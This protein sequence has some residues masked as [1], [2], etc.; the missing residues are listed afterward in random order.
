MKTKIC[1][2]THLHDAKLAIESGAWAL[3]FNFYKHSPRFLQRE[4]AREI[5][6]ALPKEIL[7]I[8]LFIDQ[9]YH[10]IQQVMKD[11]KLDLAQVYQDYDCSPDTKKSMIFVIQPF[12]EQQ[13]P[14]LDILNQYGY[15]LIDTP[16]G[17]NDLYGGTG[18]LANWDIAKH[19]S[20]HVKLILAGGLNLSNLASAIET[21]QPYAIDVCSSIESAPG[22]KDPTLLKQ[23]LTLSSH[24]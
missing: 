13:I 18:K 23:F 17:N 20:K 9:D 10:Y 5:I 7:K 2:I 8:G 24:D 4:Q 22:V 3:G 1:G 6:E 14:P 21:V 15:V 12:T 19:L 11:L 16:R